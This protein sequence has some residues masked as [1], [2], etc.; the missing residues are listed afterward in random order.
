MPD[1]RAVRLILFV[2][3]HMNHT[4]GCAVWVVNAASIDDAQ[5]RFGIMVNRNVQSTNDRIA[6]CHMDCTNI[7]IRENRSS[8]GPRQ[9]SRVL[10][11]CSLVYV[12][13]TKYEVQR[14]RNRVDVT[15]LTD[16]LFVCHLRERWGQCSVQEPPLEIR[17]GR[18]LR[19]VQTLVVNFC[20]VVAHKEGSI[21]GF[22]FGRTRWAPIMGAHLVRPILGPENDR[23]FGAQF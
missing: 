20:R 2:C 1:A 23:S 5:K 7:T 8:Q 3:V 22:I 18:L 19:K 17:L 11:R 13:F 12:M 15:Y 10:F 9:K 14:S 16:L 4:E 21:S 6:A